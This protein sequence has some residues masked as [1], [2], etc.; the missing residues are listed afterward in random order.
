[1]RPTGV[2]ATAEIRS[3]PEKAAVVAVAVAVA[4]QPVASVI[5]GSRTGKA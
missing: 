5:Y 4:D 3:A 1:M 2:P